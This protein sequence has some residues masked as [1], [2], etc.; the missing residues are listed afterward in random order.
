MHQSDIVKNVLYNKS[1]CVRIIS[2]LDEQKNC[3]RLWLRQNTHFPEYP[4]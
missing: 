1:G 4:H 3:T 2:I